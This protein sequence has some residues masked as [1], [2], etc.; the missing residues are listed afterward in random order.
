MMLS[1]FLLYGGLSSCS[2]GALL[3]L[4]GLAKGREARRLDTATRVDNLA[5]EHRRAS[6]NPHLQD[7]PP[8]AACRRLPA[9]ANLPASPA[10]PPAS[11]T[12]ASCGR[13]CPC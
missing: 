4:V 13:W 2:L 6:P 11:Q 9:A 5:G 3:G 12:C 1:S 10:P 8:P 7:L